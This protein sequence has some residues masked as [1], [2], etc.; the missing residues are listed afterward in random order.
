[1]PNTRSPSSSI[2][3]VFGVAGPPRGGSSRFGCSDRD[4]EVAR[5]STFGPAKGVFSPAAMSGRRGACTRGAGPGPGVHRRKGANGRGS[6]CDSGIAALLG[7]TSEEDF[8]AFAISPISVVRCS[9]GH[10]AVRRAA[11][12]VAT[13]RG[14][15]ILGAHRKS[16]V[17]CGGSLEPR[18]WTMSASVLAHDQPMAAE[19][20]SMAPT[21]SAKGIS[22]SSRSILSCFASQWPSSASAFAQAQESQ[23]FE[24]RV[25]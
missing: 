24:A 3:H 13:R 22:W 11:P 19:S 6:R 10:L 1:M 5:R 20:V 14:S 2:W 16:A 7:V 15:R 23:L 21:V 12:A 18:A 17:R 9:R 4:V 25:A 8:V